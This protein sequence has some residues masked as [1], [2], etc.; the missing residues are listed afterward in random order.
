MIKINVGKIYRNTVSLIQCDSIRFE[1]AFFFFFFVC[2]IEILLA[3]ETCEISMLQN[4]CVH[5]HNSMSKLIDMLEY[6][7]NFKHKVHFHN[8]LLQ[9]VDIIIIN[10]YYTWN[11][12][13]KIRQQQLNIIDAIFIVSFWTIAK[14]VKEKKKNCALLQRYTSK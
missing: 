3:F 10:Y 14:L 2:I 1:W 6:N 4:V 12:C 5:G 7:V 8:Y 11:V 9:Y 13:K